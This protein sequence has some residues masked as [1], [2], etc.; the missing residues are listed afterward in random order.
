VISH[1]N[2]PV[3][4]FDSF[5]LE[6]AER[7]FSRAGE[8]IALPPKAFEV[9]VCLVENNSR[10][11]EKENLL[12]QVWPD[13]FVEEGNLKICI[14]TLRKALAGSN[15]IETVPKKGYRFTAPV[16]A[17]GPA[18]AEYVLER[19]T[20]STVTIEASE[21][22][23]TCAPAAAGP[24]S[25][26]RFIRPAIY[27]PVAVLV[28]VGIFFAVYLGG[29]GGSDGQ[30]KI[31]S[32]FAG[33]K[34][35]AVL[36]L[37]SISN[38]P[39]EPEVRVGMS[40]SIVTKLSDV[41]Q[42]AVRPTSATI[43]YLDQNYDTIEVGR[44]LKVDSVLEGNV[45]KEGDRLR[46]TLQMVNVADGKLIWAD[47]FEN[48]LSGLFTG[49]DSVAGRVSKLM[50][51]SLDKSATVK[52]A[53]GSANP[54]AREVYLKGRYALATSVRKIENIVR[55][56]DYFEQ[57]ISADPNF[58]DAY[59]DLAGTYNTAAALNLLSPNEAFP[60]AEKAARKAL[61][62]D[63]SLASAHAEL[64]TVEADYNWNWS[65]AETEYKEALNLN[66]NSTTAQGGYAEFLARMGRFEEAERHGDISFELN[67]TSINNQAVKALGFLYAHRFDDAESQSMMVIARDRTVYLA[68]L[69]LALA[70]DAKG[71]YAGAAEAAGNATSI[72]GGTPSD[73]FVSGLGP[74]L[75]GDAAKTDEVLAHLESLSHREYADPFYSAV[76]YAAKGDKDRAFAFLDKCYN[77]KSYWITTLKVFP[78][79]DGL[80]SDPRF[81]NLLA[82]ANLTD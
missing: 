67:P 30:Q 11:V 59:S 63:P 40:D 76:L 16:R 45:Q 61:E 31:V 74:A 80:R 41:R 53:R 33:I 65:A 42:L 55:A 73:I 57:A 56:K 28:A 78:F 2:S 6:P 69:Y 3:Y 72:T 50:A 68:Y 66:P 82:R 47:S 22:N 36:P 32:P 29:A 39:V 19:Q 18:C 37:K 8:Q 1:E 62:I 60:K 5:R 43:K 51:L 23:G 10:L 64:A 44:E 79:L 14:H 34:S 21:I 20:T 81:T 71:N 35:V 7:R 54:A 25:G 38:P 52:D 75:S 27:L 15:Y 58:A 24:K 70:R 49:Q 26:S 77:E 13:S 48:D 46:I 4:E 9:L 17:A 12:N